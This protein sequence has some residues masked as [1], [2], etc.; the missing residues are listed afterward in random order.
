LVGVAG[1]GL[2]ERVVPVPGGGTGVGGSRCAC[3]SASVPRRGP[4]DRRPPV[5][6]QTVGPADGEALRPRKHPGPG[7]WRGSGPLPELVERVP[8]A[9]CSG[10]D[11]VP[12]LLLLASAWSRSA[13][14]GLQLP[15]QA[16][17]RN[18]TAR[19]LWTVLPFLGLAVGIWTE[20]AV[21]GQVAPS[22]LAGL[23]LHRGCLWAAGLLAAG[24]RAC[25]PA[26]GGEA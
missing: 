2:A 21:T 4:A 12:L 16:S 18:S 14:A 15:V 10:A 19:P 8:R 5:R 25:A 13:S 26:P 6:P 7:H 3:T 1:R 17:R 11:H 24:G 22:Y 20:R 23:A 9:S